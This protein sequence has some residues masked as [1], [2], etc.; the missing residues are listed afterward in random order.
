[1]YV[2]CRYCS[3]HTHT[4]CDGRDVLKWSRPFSVT[5]SYDVDPLTLYMPHDVATSAGLQSVG[6]SVILN[7]V[8][9]WRPAVTI[10]GLVCIGGSRSKTVHCCHGLN[11][12][13]Q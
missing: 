2:V 12:R 13:A 7:N 8:M 4:V 5:Q 10:R 1:M 11:M 9:K 6:D 3:T